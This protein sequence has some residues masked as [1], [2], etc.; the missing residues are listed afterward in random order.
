SAVNAWPLAVAVIEPSAQAPPLGP[1]GSPLSQPAAAGRRARAKRRVRGR[2]MGARGRE[3]EGGRPGPPGS[4]SLASAGR[5]RPPGTTARAKGARRAG[6]VRSLQPKRRTKPRKRPETGA[7]GWNVADRIR[8][9]R[10]RCH[11][12]DTGELNALVLEVELAEEPR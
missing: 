11:P 12:S 7:L 3:S 4:P 2:R 8:T 9:R 6:R 5:R 1:P 10:G